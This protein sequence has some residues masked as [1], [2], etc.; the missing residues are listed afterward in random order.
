MFGPKVKLEKALYEKIKM[1]STIAG[2]SSVEE[3][4]QHA[5][6]KEPPPRRRFAKNLRVWATFPDQPSHDLYRLRL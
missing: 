6:E 1:Y 3:F 4:V 2:Y 5:L